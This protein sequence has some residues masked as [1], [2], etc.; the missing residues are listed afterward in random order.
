MLFTNNNNINIVTAGERGEGR[1]KRLVVLS[2][3]HQFDTA[4]ENQQKMQCFIDTEDTGGYKRPPTKG[5][6]GATN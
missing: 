3:N 4:T 5:P 6:W 1:E 2:K